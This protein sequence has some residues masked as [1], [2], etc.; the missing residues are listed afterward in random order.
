MDLSIII[1]CYN[2][3]K[4]LHKCLA[5]ISAIQGLSYEL[6]LIND[7]S[8]D[9]T[10]KLLKE[11]VENYHGKAILIEKEN[12]GLS[13]ARNVGLENA[14]GQYIM[15]LDSDDYICPARL[16]DIINGMKKDN[17]DVAFFDYKKE[18]DGILIKDKSSMKR[19][20]KTKSL[21]ESIQGIEY[22]ERV[23]D[24]TT[25]FIHSEACFAIYS[26]DFLSSHSLQFEKGI[27]HEDTLFFYQMIVNADKVKYYDYDIYVYVIREGSITTDSSKEIKRANDKLYIA[28]K[29]LDLK[30][31]EH[32][33][34][35]FVDSMIINFVFFSTCRKR[36]KNIYDL[37]K[38]HMCKKLS[39]KS[40]IMI[41]IMKMCKLLER[42]T[43]A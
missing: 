27:C 9:N 20:K 1:P 4:Y 18:I 32:L 42:R 15:F 2:V 8:T 40:R 16:L 12:G 19:C 38:L 25:N 28:T 30:C 43:R 10:D 39:M 5:S 14:V 37:S 3:E 21:L 34:F 36:I 35:Y 6:V 23:F 41:V 13:D 11:F 17:L 7:G 31:K 29:I 22:A 24:K 26:R 33:D